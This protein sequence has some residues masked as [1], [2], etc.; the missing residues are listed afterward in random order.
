MEFKTCT[1]TAIIVHEKKIVPMGLTLISSVI[2]GILKKHNWH[3]IPSFGAIST[4]HFWYVIFCSSDGIT[5]EL[6]D[7]YHQ[8]CYPR[9]R[10]SCQLILLPA[11]RPHILHYHLLKILECDHFPYLWWNAWVSSTF[12]IKS[13]CNF[14][15]WK[16]LHNNSKC[17]AIDLWMCFS[18]C[19]LHCSFLVWALNRMLF[20]SMK[21]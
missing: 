14:P 20:F 2:L 10:T 21:Y 11:P 16:L 17:Y 3:V 12:S 8:Y 19:R 9:T 13:S 5:F 1:V 4:S 18:F 15:D 6:V 7:E